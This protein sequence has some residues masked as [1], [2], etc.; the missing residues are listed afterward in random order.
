MV[1]RGRVVAYKRDEM[2]IRI[3]DVLMKVRRCSN[4][5]AP[6]EIHVIIPH[7]EIRRRFDKFGRK[8]EE[9][10]ILDSITIVDSPVHE[11][12][13]GSPHPPSIPH[14][15]WRYIPDPGLDAETLRIRYLTKKEPPSI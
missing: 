11:P 15:T 7:A 13:G 6:S 1:G 2:T 5:P 8:T 14:T 4:M 3:A 9:D 10:L 12:L